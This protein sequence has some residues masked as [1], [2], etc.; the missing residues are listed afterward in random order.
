LENRYGEAAPELEVRDWSGRFSPV[1]CITLVLH[2]C[3]HMRRG[4]VYVEI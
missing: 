4:A 1:R 2:T 3:S